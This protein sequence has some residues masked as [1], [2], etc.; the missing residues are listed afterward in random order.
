[1]DKTA[2]I[3]QLRSKRR[4]LFRTY[5]FHVGWFTSTC[6]TAATDSY[7]FAVVSSLWLVLVTLPPVLAYTYLVHKAIRAVE[8]SA[9]S[10]GLRQ[11]VISFVFFSPLEAGLVLPAINLW[12]SHRILR[13]WNKSRTAP[14]TSTRMVAQVPLTDG[15]KTKRRDIPPP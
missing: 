2:L 1:M 4:R 11:I 5:I 6:A 8:P 9:N 12:I 13:A 15:K 10:M 14:I 7:H 3:E